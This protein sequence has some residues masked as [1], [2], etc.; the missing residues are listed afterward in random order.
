MEVSKVYIYPNPTRNLLTVEAKDQN[1]YTIGVFALNGRKMQ[2]RNFSGNTI[3]IDLSDYPRGVYFISLATKD[4]VKT[5]RI[6][7]L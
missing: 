2:S 1:K 3:Q 6:F 5:K 7:K 4:A